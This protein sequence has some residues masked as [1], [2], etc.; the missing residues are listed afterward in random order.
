MDFITLIEDRIYLDIDANNSDDVFQN[1]ASGL[2]NEDLS[3]SNIYQHLLNRE[4]FGST[5]LGFSV[6][7]PHGRIKGIKEPLLSI[8]RTKQDINF[9]APDNMPVKIFIGI[10]V[11]ELANQQHLDLLA[12]IA[13]ML[14]DDD[15]RQ[16]LMIE[17]SPAKII[18]VIQDY[19]ST[20]SI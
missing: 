20:Q 9:N 3:S 10:L 17:T 8:T 12:N 1:I 19:Q 11:P 13:M 14:S 4:S 2:A 7:I 18:Q 15:L 5:G 16:T 6:A